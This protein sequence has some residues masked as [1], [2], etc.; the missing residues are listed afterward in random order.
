MS[1]S[2]RLQ[3]ASGKI[4]SDTQI[5]GSSN[6]SLT[7]PSF[8]FKE[9]SNTGMYHVSNQTLGFVTGGIEAFHVSPTDFTITSNL[10]VG[11]NI[12]A[13]G[14]LTM[15][16]RLVVS[17]LKINRKSGVDVNV[18]SSSVRGFSNVSTG[19]ILDIGSNAPASGQSMRVTW[20][21]NSELMR[22]T[23]DGNVG[24]GTSSPGYKL[25]VSGDIYATGNV[26]A[27]SDMRAKSNLDVIKE[28]LNKLSQLTGYTYD[29]TDNPD[30]TTKITPR[31]TGVI[32]QDLEKVLPEAVH[33]DKDGKYSV[34]YGNMAGL[35]VE[36][37]KELIE[38]NKVLKY[39]VNTLEKRLEVLERMIGST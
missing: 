22:L 33:K 24:V 14:N 37:F 11:S 4:Y 32:A 21:N 15:N 30:L 9:E 7:T 18:T 27:Y 31:F 17:T 16:N 20:S 1:P 10:T 8:S 5:L 36:S 26:T 12:I 39:R 35:F 13:N 6:D 34:A 19:I 28:P 23:G 29:M 25:H 2:E 38:E 3:V